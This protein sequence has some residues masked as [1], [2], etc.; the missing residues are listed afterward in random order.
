VYISRNSSKPPIA[1][2]RIS[3]KY[4]CIIEKSIEDDDYYSAGYYYHKDIKR[5]CRGKKEIDEEY[6]KIGELE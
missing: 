3:D 1:K 4:I 2:F 5:D 6:I